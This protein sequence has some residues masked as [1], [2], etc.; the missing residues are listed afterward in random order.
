MFLIML[1][2]YLARDLAPQLDQ[3]KCLRYGRKEICNCCLLSCPTDAITITDQVAFDQGKCRGCG[4]CAA[5]CPAGCLHFNEV[6]WLRLIKEIFSAGIAEFGCSASKSNRINAV[7]PCLAGIPAEIFAIVDQVTDHHFTL[8]LGPCRNCHNQK[9]IRQIKPTLRQAA[10][11]AGRPVSYKIINSYKSNIPTLAINRNNILEFQPGELA[12]FK[13]ILTNQAVTFFNTQ[14]G[15]S[16]LTLSGNFG[17]DANNLTPLR[18]T[19]LTALNLKEGVS[20][21]LPSWQV[22]SS[23]TACKRCVGACIQK[24]WELVYDNHKACL[25]HNPLRCINCG[26]CST[27]CQQQALEPALVKMDKSTETAQIRKI[28]TIRKCDRCNKDF[29][30]HNNRDRHCKSCENREKLRKSIMTSAI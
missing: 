30:F 13:K 27:S 4:T 9:V 22:S 1:A 21:V 18:S 23:C 28:F 19:L 11:L 8:D 17:E 3:T 12:G 7:V 5:A 10:K 15:S 6:S 24:A 2:R 26:R 14:T 25:I 29:I 16:R 20:F